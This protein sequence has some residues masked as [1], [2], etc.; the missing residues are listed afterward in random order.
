SLR[1]HFELPQQLQITSLNVRRTGDNLPT[2]RSSLIQSEV[3]FRVQIK[4]HRL[5]V[6]ETHH[7]VRRNFYAI[8]E[9]DHSLLTTTAGSNAA[10]MRMQKQKAS[11]ILETGLMKVSFC[12]PLGL[13]LASFYLGFDALVHRRQSIDS[14]F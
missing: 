8:R 5:V 3:T 4:K 14:L 7:H 12:R 11:V 6:E 1:R 13:L 9:H 2:T 10:A